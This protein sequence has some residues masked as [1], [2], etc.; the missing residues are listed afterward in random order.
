MAILFETYS[1]A[2]ELVA[3]Q[4]LFSM[5]LDI[6]GRRAM[7]VCFRRGNVRV[8][9]LANNIPLNGT[10]F[11]V[12]CIKSRQRRLLYLC[13]GILRLHVAYGHWS[14]VKCR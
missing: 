6:D 3:W 9:H 8:A 12:S 13:M 7:T 14:T 4:A 5:W 2:A 11:D 1:I 10:Q